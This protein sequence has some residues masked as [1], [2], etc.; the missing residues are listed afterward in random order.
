MII[1]RLKNS[2]AKT[3]LSAGFILLYSL[4]FCVSFSFISAFFRELLLIDFFD[5]LDGVRLVNALVVPYAGYPRE[6][7]RHLALV[8]WAPLNL[9]VRDFESITPLPCDWASK[10]PFTYN[11]AISPSQLPHM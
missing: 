8:G 7:Q 5:S 11:L 4:L 3:F 10:I 9:I 1:W 2:L 6:P